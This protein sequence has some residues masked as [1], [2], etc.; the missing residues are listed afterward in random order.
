MKRIIDFIYGLF[1]DSPTSPSMKRFIAFYLS[2]N[3][4]VALYRTNPMSD[5]LIYSITALIATLLGL[6]VVEKGI[7]MY[8]DKKD[9]DAI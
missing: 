2:I 8:M 5:V 6:K 3:L 4:G 9:K 1:M 7:K